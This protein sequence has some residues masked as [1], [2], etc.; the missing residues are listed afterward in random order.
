LAKFGYQRPYFLGR[1]KE[2]FLQPDDPY[3]IQCPGTPVG[4][5]TLLIRPLRKRDVFQLT[6]AHHLDPNVHCFVLALPGKI[7]PDMTNE[8]L[9]R[10]GT[11]AQAW[12]QKPIHVCE[13]G[14]CFACGNKPLCQKDPMAKVQEEVE[15]FTKAAKKDLK[16]DQAILIAYPKYTPKEHQIL[17]AWAYSEDP[18]EPSIPIRIKVLAQRFNVH[19]R[20][21]YRL[22]LKAQEDNFAIF[23]ILQAARNERLQKSG[24]GI[25]DDNFN[26][27][28]DD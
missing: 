23:T 17:H 8:D 27:A 24:A 18:Y 15:I 19:K 10:W 11:E 2:A 5:K 16:I 26:P 20:T 6:Q 3:P 25:V 21:I 13:Q 1:P 28:R 4:K 22:I 12:V 9:L 14:K 7:V